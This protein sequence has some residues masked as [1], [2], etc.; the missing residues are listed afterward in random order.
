MGS[1]ISFALGCFLSSGCAEPAA[2]PGT[3]PPATCPRPPDPWCARPSVPVEHLVST[4]KVTSNV[5]AVDADGSRG[6]LVTATR[7]GRLTIIHDEEERSWP[8]A[9]LIQSGACGLPDT[10]FTSV[11]VGIS[12][13]DKE[14][15]FVAD[16]CGKR[17]PACTVTAACLVDTETGAARDLRTELGEPH[18]LPAMGSAAVGPVFIALHRRFAA[19]YGV[20]YGLEFVWR[21]THQLESLD[22]GARTG[23]CVAVPV[24]DELVVACTPPYGKIRVARFDVS[25]APHRLLASHDVRVCARSPGIQLSADG[26]FVGFYPDFAEPTSFMGVIDTGDGHVLFETDARPRVK[27]LEFVPDGDALMVVDDD[28]RLRLLGVDGHVQESHLLDHLPSRAFAAGGKRVWI[29]GT[30]GLELY[31]F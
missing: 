18:R 20:W 25:R 21:D 9:E 4:P 3:P 24:G 28:H 5:E 22:L 30:R 15:W 13:D 19:L 10:Y 6:T 27:I 1:R 8:I 7:D 16:Q 31:E 17:D 14:A 26:R 2:K 23:D 11:H 12:A 29:H